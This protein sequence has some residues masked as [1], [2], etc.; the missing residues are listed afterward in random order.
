M[1]VCI[2]FLG[3]L[4]L[5]RSFVWSCVYMHICVHA[6]V[7]IF[8]HVFVCPLICVCLCVY[9]CVF[10]HMY[11]REHVCMCVCECAHVCVHVCH[12]V[13]VVMSYYFYPCETYFDVGKREGNLTPSVF[14]QKVI[15]LSNRCTT[16]NQ[17]AFPKHHVIVTMY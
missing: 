3:I 9:I 14:F 10:G 13:A 17:A 4:C 7:C 11:E 2:S 5:S 16:S 1:S 6:H 8:V 12:S 15:A